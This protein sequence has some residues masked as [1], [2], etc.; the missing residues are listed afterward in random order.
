MKKPTIGNSQDGNDGAQV[1]ALELA[2]LTVSLIGAGMAGHGEDRR[3]VAAAALELIET[4]DGVIDVARAAKAWRRELEA[5]SFAVDR[6]VSEFG[7]GGRIPLTRVLKLARADRLKP[8]DAEM[9]K[10]KARKEWNRMSGDERARAV[11]L[12]LTLERAPR[13]DAI[14]YRAGGYMIEPSGSK[15]FPERIECSVSGVPS[16]WLADYAEGLMWAKRHRDSKLKSAAAKISRIPKRRDE[17]GKY[18]ETPRE[19]EGKFKRTK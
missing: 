14:P 2:H 13:L 11:F 18:V 15:G 4:C 12:V 1:T 10:I 5:L 19:R 8:T 17:S 3:R 7:E 16:L 6:L 9:K